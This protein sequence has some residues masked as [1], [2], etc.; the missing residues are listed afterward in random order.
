MGQ[1][2][3][4]YATKRRNEPVRTGAKIESSQSEEGKV[5]G[6]AGQKGANWPKSGELE[7][8]SPAKHS[9]TSAAART[10]EPAG[11]AEISTKEHKESNGTSRENTGRG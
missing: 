1:M 2:G 8:F 11:S 5:L 4:K 3:R 9:G 6:Q 7:D 10:P